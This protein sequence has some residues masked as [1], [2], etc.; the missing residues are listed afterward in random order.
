[1]STRVADHSPTVAPRPGPDDG[2]EGRRQRG[3]AIAA[4]TPIKASR[5]GYIVPSQS[6]NGSC[7]VSPDPDDP[8]RTCPD[9]EERQE[10]CKHHYAGEF[11]VQRD[12]QPPEP[13]AKTRKAPREPLG[14]TWTAYNSA[15]TNEQEL[16]GILLHE[17]CA[18]VPQPPQGNGRPRLPLSDMLFVN[19]M[20]VYGTRSGRRAMTDLRNAHEAGLISCC[21]SFTTAFRYM[22]DPTLYRTIKSLIEL[23]SLPLKALET[24][25]AAD[26]TG[27][28][29]SVYD[30]W[31]DHK[32]GKEK[33]QARFVKAHLMCGVNTKVVTAVEVTEAYSHDSPEFPKLVSTTASNFAMSEVSADKAYLSRSNLRAAVDAGAIPFIPFKS[34]SR[35][36]AEKDSLWNYLYHYFNL[37]RD[38]F[39][40]YYHKRS[41]SE[42]VNS[43]MKAKFGGFLRSKA[44]NAQMNEALVKILCHNICVLIQAMYSLGIEPDFAAELTFASKS[45]FDAKVA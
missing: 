32:W 31:F 38:E 45:P 28:S 15:Q 30:R 8:F 20:K 27:F 1:M 6:G 14:W 19:A 10:P 37:R 34:N 22:E 41:I 25:F 24:D 4:I 33:K 35:P 9:F 43:M 36:G 26:A 12:S 11:T 21:P 3:M 17:L 13:E 7:V 44:P 16:F 2:D 39:M 18:V 29:T 40:A 5:L 42:S 23:S